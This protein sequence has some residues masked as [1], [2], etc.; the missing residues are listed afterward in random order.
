M[1]YILDAL[2]KSDLQRQQA[3]APTLLTAHALP[4]TPKRKNLGLNIV[5]AALLITAGVLIGWLQPWRT[6]PPPAPTPALK[7]LV[8]RA[9]PA[10]AVPVQAPDIRREPEIRPP[11]APKPVAGQHIETRPKPG[12]AAQGDSSTRA[13]TR[14][15]SKSD[16]RTPVDAVAIPASDAS[17]FPRQQDAPIVKQSE[18]PAEIRQALPNIVIA[19][20]Q[21][22]P[23]P[24]EQRVMI[25]N[26]V[27]RP[28]EMLSPG[29]RL[30]QITADGVVLSFQN[31]RFRHGLR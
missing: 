3:K 27:L 10:Q 24:S 21:Y 11:E 30:E 12:P 15:P 5:I 22:S 6:T 26:I 20:H 2:R 23:V 13:E 8:A 17:P 31:Y 1:S 25:N 28:G 18:L 29:L 19:F 7:P 16:E 4:D 14:P 9:A